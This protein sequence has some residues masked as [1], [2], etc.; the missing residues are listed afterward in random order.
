MNLAI[1]GCLITIAVYDAR[2]NRIP[3]QLLLFI[4]VAFIVESYLIDMPLMEIS[5]AFSSGALFFI[6][7]LIFYFL[8]AMAPGD[9]KLLGVIGVIVGWGALLSVSYWILLAGALIGCFYSLEKMSGDTS[10]FKMWA[11]KILTY[12][13]YGVRAEPSTLK[14][15]QPEKLRM[16]FAPVVVVGLAL[17]S[18]F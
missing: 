16:P 17:H 4:L 6:I 15:N 7:G 3:N 5:K 9:V 10:R 1:W 14:V 8:G 2:D 11:D 12:F 13:F 18:Y